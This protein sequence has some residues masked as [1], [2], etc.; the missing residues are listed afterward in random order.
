MNTIQTHLHPNHQRGEKL[1]AE[2]TRLCSYMYAADYRLLKLIHEFDEAGGWHWEGLYSCA[3]WL[4]WQC[5]IGM[6]AARE[7]VRVAKQLPELPKISAAFAKGEISYSKVRAMTRIATN[8]N[9]DFLLMIARH[10]TASHMEELVS[11]YRRVKRLEDDYNS[12]QQ[13][14][15]VAVEGKLELWWS[16]SQISRWLVK[17]IS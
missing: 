16:P 17:G 1:G 7:K 8:E 15:R 9:E 4:N 12:N 6:N 10:G 3:H 2:I 13:R 5:G 14:L 11:K